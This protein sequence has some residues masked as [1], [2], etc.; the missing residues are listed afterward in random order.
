MQDTL[1]IGEAARRAGTTPKALRYYEE[2]GLLPHTTRAPNGYRRYR[3]ED[4]NRIIFIRRSKALGLTLEEIR[5]L[6]AVAEGGQCR[7]TK[8]ELTQLLAR[9]I[10]D[11]TERIETLTGFRAMLEHA[12]RQVSSP[13]EPEAET[14]CASCAAFAP[15]CACLPI[16][17]PLNLDLPR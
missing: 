4:L 6:V 9:K 14:C 7:L 13:G 3:V 8:A 17:P 15:S 12:A 1:A 5:A 11:C 16:P 2:V 10:T